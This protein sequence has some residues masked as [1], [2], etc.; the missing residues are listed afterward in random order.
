MLGIIPSAGKGKR[1]GEPSKALTKING[2]FLIEYPL[3]NMLDLGIKEVIIIQNENDIENELKYDW[4][5]ITLKYVTQKEKN[6]SAKAIYLA[7]DL[8]NEDSIV[9]LGDIIFDGNLK[10]MKERFYSSGVNCLAGGQFV[11]DKSVIKESYGISRG[12]FVE[13]P[14]NLDEISNIL[15]LGIFMF[16]KTLF[17]KIEE[18]EINPKKNEYDIISTLN[19]FDKNG[20]FILEGKYL[21]I[22]TPE[23]LKKA[24]ENNI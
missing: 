15:G 16:D 12:V 18:T 13:K 22:N 19:H 24:N 10:K 23:E 11:E 9:I 4:N 2:K 8:C 6:G 20:F 1:L 17:K 14:E 3:K 21:N 5:G 7:K